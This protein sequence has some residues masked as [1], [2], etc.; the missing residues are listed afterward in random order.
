MSHPI[1]LTAYRAGERELVV[2]F[3]SDQI[4]GVVGSAEIRVTYPE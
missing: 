2:N 1:L 4:V 3:S